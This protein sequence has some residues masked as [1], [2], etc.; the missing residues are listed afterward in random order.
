M[1]RKK[2]VIIFDLDGVIF[3][4]VNYS[5]DYLRQI[6]P[7]IT[8]E[9]I[10]ELLCGN[11]HEGFEKLKL[12]LEQAEETDEEKE[13]R[14]LAYAEKKATALMFDGIKEL[15]ERFHGEGYRL[16]IN[17]SALERNCLPLLEKAGVVDK[18][19]LIASAEF[20]KSKVEKFKLID[21]K[22]G[23]AKED[24]VFITDTLGDLREADTANIST[25]A[26]LWG[27]HS[28]EYF[29]RERHENLIGVVN[30]VEELEEAIKKYF[31][32]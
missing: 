31:N 22:F 3:D 7:S 25:I 17:T 14:K 10:S 16:V 24:T 6:F 4:T 11:F 26:V 23:A 29:A 21:E 5:D 27:A 8:K 20:S 18:F 1:D 19:D 12:T 32:G 28:E 15:V 30:T 2:K 9:I 13:A